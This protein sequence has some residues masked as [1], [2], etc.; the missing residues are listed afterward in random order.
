MTIMDKQNTLSEDQNV[1]DTA[2]STNIID[3]SVVAPGVENGEPVSILSQVT[4]GFGTVTSVIASVQTDTVSTFAS[5]T[6]LLT[7][8]TVLQAAAVAGKE[9]L[10]GTVIPGPTERY[11]RVYYTVAGGSTAAETGTITSALVLDKQTNV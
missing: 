8:P 7:G 11:L 3:L 5:P 6:T 4:T 10:A 2:A 9:L 1:L